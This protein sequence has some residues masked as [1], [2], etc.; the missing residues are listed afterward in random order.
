MKRLAPFMIAA[1]LFGGSVAG[2]RLYVD[3]GMEKAGEK[4][5]SLIYYNTDLRN[6][7]KEALGW[8]LEE[9]SIP[10][11][12]SS[13]LSASDQVAYPPYLYKNGNS[14]FNMVLIGR[15]YMQS[16]H[17]AIT[18]GGMADRIP[19]KKAVLILSPQWFTAGHLDSG[20][21]ASRFLE[22]MYSEFLKNPQ[23][24][25]E[26]KRQVTDR[27]KSLLLEDPPQLERIEKYEDVYV[28]GSINPVTHI[29]VGLYD[30]FMNLRQEYLF[31]KTVGTL[32]GKQEGESEESETVESEKLDFRLLMEAAERAGQEA[33]TNNSFYIY[34][35]YYDTYVRNVE[36]ERR[37]SEMYGSY[38][39][40][41]EYD[42][43]RI[44]LDV[45]QETGI[46]PLV[47]S[48]PVNGRWYDWTGFPAEG[49]EA[50]Y[51]NIRRICGEYQV[52]L[53]DFS[54]KEYEIYFLKDIMHMGW[55]G[56]VYLDE[57]VYRFWK[58]QE[59]DKTGG[60]GD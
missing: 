42:D 48:V 47:I 24:S 37:G 40:S 30:S 44:F 2:V 18:L 50:Y 56:W 5:E 3:T 34:D 10:V 43:L 32:P 20:T 35:E 26:I 46:E 12:G 15:G 22:R 21:Y 51:E 9:N 19:D 33:C 14:D 55:K 4:K 13:E 17:H 45:C 8:V 54:D 7:C 29:E 11:F 38:G 39:T 6:S 52:K 41:P 58:D 49:R 23:I 27:L 59:M 1:A 25:K 60:D 16:L 57:A 36:Q 28:E 53:A 31:G